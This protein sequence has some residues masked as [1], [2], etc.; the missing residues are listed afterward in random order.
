[1]SQNERLE[2][3]LDYERTRNMLG[4]NELLYVIEQNSNFL[5]VMENK[6]FDKNAAYLLELT[7]AAI[8]GT[9]PPEPDDEVDF[10]A[11]YSLAKAHDILNLTC[12]AIDRLEHKPE[13]ELLKKWQFNRNQCVHRSMIQTA[14]FE[15]ICRAFEKKHIEYLPVKGLFIS[16]LYPKTDYRF[17]SD[18]DI[19]VRK[20]QL[21]AADGIMLSLGYEADTLGYMYDDS[22]NKKPF[23]HVELHHELFP[24]NSPFHEYFDDVLDRCGGKYG[25]KMSD[26]DA[27]IYIMAHMCK[28]Y[29]ES[30]TGIRS[31]ADTYLLNR[32]Y[33]PT[34]DREYLD[35][36]L[37]RL[38]IKEFVGVISEIADKWFSD[39]SFDSF[40]REERYI[41]NSGIYGTIEQ[42]VLNRRSELG[43]KHFFLRRIFPPLNLMKDIFRP[44]RK[45]P[46]LVP[47]FYVYRIVR[48]I[49]PSRRKKIKE[50]LRI[51]RK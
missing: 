46:F 38:E 30:G 35:A 11:V 48:L 20:E 50:E 9:Q 13:P 49:L 42:K 17:M 7:A 26:E 47:V 44:V 10:Q 32:R 43:E 14:E 33:M 15:A 21:K 27:Y 37:I 8:N 40:S 45:F 39:K 19:L 16:N 22:F 34:M 36:E 5:N 12:Y 4:A 29:R 23:M 25:K 18:L 51:V 31:V 1:M 3:Y 41:L 6:S 2:N 28:H 24:L